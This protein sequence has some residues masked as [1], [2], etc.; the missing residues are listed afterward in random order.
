MTVQVFSRQLRPDLHINDFDASFWKTALKSPH[1]TGSFKLTPLCCIG[2]S[3]PYRASSHKAIQHATEW[4]FGEAN[5]SELYSAKLDFEIEKHKIYIARKGK[6]LQ[7]SEKNTEVEERHPCGV[8]QDKICSLC[9]SRQL[10]TN[11]SRFW[12]DLVR[13]AP[14]EWSNVRLVVDQ[15]CSHCH[16]FLECR[17]PGR[18]LRSIMR[19]YKD[20]SIKNFWICWFE[21]AETLTR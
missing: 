6:W 15:E 1:H 13:S 2:A 3:N 12:F 14:P 5:V 19:N 9:C 8:E 17:P 7:V 4:R 16:F 18:W 21:R 11:F 10:H 20:S